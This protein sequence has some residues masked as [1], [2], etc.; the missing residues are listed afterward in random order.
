MLPD[1]E[2]PLGS[3]AH[4]DDQ[5]ELLADTIGAVLDAL[6]L[7]QDQRLFALATAQASLAGGAADE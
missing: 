7:S 2:E 1:L 5:G 6:D 3:A 4:L